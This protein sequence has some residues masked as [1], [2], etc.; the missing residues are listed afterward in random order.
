[1]VTKYC[2]ALIIGLL[3]AIAVCSYKLY[4]T[5]FFL[6][7]KHADFS[8]WKHVSKPHRAAHEKNMAC[9]NVGLVPSRFDSESIQFSEAI[10]VSIFN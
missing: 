3:V 1:M 6:Q 8:L 5:I 9:P 7:H 2:K 4:L 10:N